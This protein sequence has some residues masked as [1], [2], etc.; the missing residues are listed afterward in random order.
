MAHTSP[1]S[2]GTNGRLLKHSQGGVSTGAPPS[3]MSIPLEV[4]RWVT[5]REGLDA[6][7][8]A[9]RDRC[10]ASIAKL[11]K[12]F[13]ADQARVILEAARARENARRKLDPGL[14][15]ALIA[16]KAGVEMASSSRSSLHKSNR[17]ARVLGAGSHIADLC[18][19]I[20]ADAWGLH[21]SGFRVSGVDSSET[22]AVMFMHNLPECDVIVG[23]ALENCPA[24]CDAF[25]LDPARRTDTN[26]IRSIDDFQPGP[27]AWDQII[28]QLG[29]GAIKLNP[30]VDAYALPQGEIEI[31]SESGSLTQAVLWVG[32]LAGETTRSASVLTN[33]GSCTIC[34]EPCRPDDTSE[35]GSFLGTLDPCVERADLVGTLLDDAGAALVHPGT[36]LVTAETQ[37]EHPMIR[38]Y[39]TVEVLPWNKK[40]VKAALRSLDAGIV[41][42]RTRGG[43]INPDDVQR[44]LRGIGSRSDISVLVY[45]LG[46][47]VVAIIAKQIPMKEPAG[48]GMPTGSDGGHGNA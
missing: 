9:P 28:G 45:R 48:T 22:R 13:D 12:A 38:W 36:G 21:R 26:R 27:D 8:C 41:E 44:S 33:G 25:H 14:S 2:T 18:C 43:V 31:I 32:E 3:C 16:D 5:T 19:G 24:D 15:V 42:V 1:I 6:V 40:R 47:R 7:E 37:L 11:R 29:T 39:R 46:E 23:D 20:G 10:P 17:F 34:G 35:I 30:G 4:W